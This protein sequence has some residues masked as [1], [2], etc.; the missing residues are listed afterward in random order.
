MSQLNKMKK[1]E[2]FLEN[3]KTAI[4]STVK[5][6]SETENVDVSFGQKKFDKNKLVVNLPELENINNKI[7][8]TKARALADSEAL[9]IR[10]SNE[11]IFK[12]YEPKGSVSKKLYSIA[13][14]IRY[15]KIGSMKFKG[16]KKNINKNYN[17][18]LKTLDLNKSE[19]KFSEAFESYLRENI[20]DLKNDNPFEKELKSIKKKLIQNLRV[21]YYH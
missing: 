7:N 20:L 4:I 15:E 12:T 2:N 5:S 16:I 1:D 3:F 8:Y 13:E 9:K 10:Y 21:N 6:L 19:D 17:E 14:K 18:R 11:K